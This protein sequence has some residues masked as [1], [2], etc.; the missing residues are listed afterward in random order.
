[1]RDCRSDRAATTSPSQS[2]YPVALKEESSDALDR[3]MAR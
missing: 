1:M 3:I 2:N